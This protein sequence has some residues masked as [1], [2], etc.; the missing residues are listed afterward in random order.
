[1][2]WVPRAD[3]AIHMTPPFRHRLTA[4]VRVTI[5]ALC[6]GCAWTGDVRAATAADDRLKVFRLPPEPVDQAILRFALQADVSVGWTAGAAGA[7]RAAL[8][9]QSPIRNGGTRRRMPVL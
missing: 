4:I 3:A 1:M 8:A 5:V 7:A 6:A 2:V 9:A